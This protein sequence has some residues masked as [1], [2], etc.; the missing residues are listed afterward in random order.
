M[1]DVRTQSKHML[2]KS[3][4]QRK[5]KQ[6]LSRV[7]QLVCCVCGSAGVHVHHLQNSKYG[8]SMGRKSLDR[9][10]VP[11]CEVCHMQGVH[12]IGSKMEPLWF[13]QRG[14]KVERLAEEL[15]ECNTSDEMKLL[16]LNHTGNQDA[17]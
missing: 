7:A 13:L 15:Y 12:A 16:L 10:V 5:D 8:R 14:I 4:E 11:L 6:H 2:Q 9:W 1:L 17:T 3:N